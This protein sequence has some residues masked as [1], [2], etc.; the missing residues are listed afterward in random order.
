MTDV[1]VV[2]ADDEPLV[3]RGLRAFIGASPGLSLVGEARN[4][5]EA[6][7]VIR[8]QRPDL[9]FLDVQM[10]ELDGFG[11]LEALAGEPMPVIVFV[12]AYDEY[13]IRA[14]DV[15]AVDYL[16]KPFDEDRFRTALGRARS[17][18]AEQRADTIDQRL[19]AVL[20]ALR[21]REQ[22]AD[23]LLVKS[24]GRVTVV[25][26]DDVDWIEAADNYA[27][28]HTARGRY[29]VREPIKSLERKLNPRRFA[30]VHRSAIVNLARVRELQPMF[31][32]EYVIILSTGT[33]LTLSR[34]YR[35]AFR[36]RLGSEI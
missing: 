8:A 2:I 17:R 10:P 13:A 34:G 30:R 35:D 25:Q 26:V 14:F 16:L 36:D 24:E 21:A 6:V 19:E 3:R 31:G 20:S 1:R 33:K 23:R 29:L 11:V 5:S 32:G 12:T 9:L 7:G 4:G 27:R 15:H 28:V 18:L 22:Y